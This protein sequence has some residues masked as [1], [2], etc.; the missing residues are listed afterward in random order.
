MIPIQEVNVAAFIPKKVV[1]SGRLFSCAHCLARL[2]SPAFVSRLSHLTLL[3][4]SFRAPVLKD[5]DPLQTLVVLRGSLA[6]VD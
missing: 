6:G 1:E 3:S 4:A 5:E 2:I